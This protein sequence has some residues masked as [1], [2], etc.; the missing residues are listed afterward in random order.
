MSTVDNIFLLH[1]L[2]NKTSES[3]YKL[4]CAFIDN[5]KAYDYVVRDYLL[6]KLIQYGIRGRLLNIIISM[7]NDIKSH[8]KL[9]NQISNEFTCILG[10]R[11][12]E[13]LSPFYFICFLMTLKMNLL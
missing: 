1:V 3:G 9:N 13:C 11:Q 6:Y 2:I 12:G 10:V 5:R 7:Y 8:V 4:Y